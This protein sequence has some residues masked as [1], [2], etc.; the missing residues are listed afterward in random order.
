LGTPVLRVVRAVAI[1]CAVL[2]AALFGVLAL[3]VVPAIPAKLDAAAA[4]VATAGQ[5]K[6]PVIAILVMPVFAG[7][8]APFA[9]GAGAWR[10]TRAAAVALP[11][12]VLHVIAALV[13]VAIALVAGVVPG[14]LVLAPALLIGAAVA[15]GARGAAAFDAAA[16]LAAPRRWQLA[17]L[18]VGLVAAVIGAAVVL[19]KLLLPV[20]TKKS[21][22]IQI[23]AAYR[24][25]WWNA[26]A[27]AALVAIG[28][29]TLA[30]LHARYSHRDAE[31]A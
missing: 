5:W 24:Y 6:V 11:A 3:L 22:A 1:P 26:I 20:L 12:I 15:T 23:A 27:L 10:A 30:V 28:A 17:A 8:A 19:R 9:R 4:R 31:V 21:A 29:A 2:G 13:L 16:A 18:A 7:L 14:L 25:A